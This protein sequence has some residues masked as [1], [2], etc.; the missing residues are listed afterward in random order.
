MKKKKI[1]TVYKQM[2]ELAGLIQRCMNVLG[3]YTI[4]KL[5]SSAPGVKIISFYSKIISCTMI[6]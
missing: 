3:Y 4:C 2:T 6:E 5:Q 1:I